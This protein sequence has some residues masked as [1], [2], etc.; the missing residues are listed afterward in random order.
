MRKSTLERYWEEEEFKGFFHDL[1]AESGLERINEYVQHGLHHPAAAQLGR[2]LLQLPAG[3]FS[4]GFPSIGKSWCAAPFSTIISFTTPQDGDPRPQGP[5]D[6]PSPHRC[7]KRQAGDGPHPHRGGHHPLPTC[8]PSP[9]S[10]PNTGRAWWSLWWTKPARC[11]SSSG[12]ASPIPNCAP[13]C[14][15]GGL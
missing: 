6:A 4:P 10:R 13:R 11:T 12:A 9:S 15:Y 14:P 7:G 3:P 5:L 1:L 2:S 8:S